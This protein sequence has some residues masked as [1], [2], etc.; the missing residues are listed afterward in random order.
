M[1]RVVTGDLGWATGKAQ[2]KVKVVCGNRFGGSVQSSLF[3]DFAAAECFRDKVSQECRVGCFSQVEGATAIQAPFSMLLYLR[4]CVFLTAH[5]W[6]KVLP[7]LPALP[8]ISH[9]S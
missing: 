1:N 4:R 5:P 9:V 7:A 2:L 3:Q 6:Q 8:I